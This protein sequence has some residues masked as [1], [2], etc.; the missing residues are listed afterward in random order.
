[1]QPRP[2][3]APTPAVLQIPEPASEE[4]NPNGAQPLAPAHESAPDPMEMINAESPLPGA[5]ELRVSTAPDVASPTERRTDGDSRSF[6]GFTSSTHVTA[7]RA[8]TEA[9]PVPLE[10]SPAN[11]AP[12]VPGGVRF[13][14]DASPR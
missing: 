10:S 7:S 3:P 11:G 8:S 13:P 14:R 1:V 2:T 4:T 5:N 9:L 12:P 6:F